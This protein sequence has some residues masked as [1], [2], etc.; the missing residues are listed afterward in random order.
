MGFN[1]LLR[2]T[3]LRR[4]LGKTKRRTN[5]PIAH[6]E[7]SPITTYTLR[8]SRWADFARGQRQN[9]QSQIRH[10]SRRFSETLPRRSPDLLVRGVL[11]TYLGFQPCPRC[12]P[13]TF[14]LSAQRIS[15]SEGCGHRYLTRYRKRMTE[16]K[17]VRPAAV[18]ACDFAPL[19]KPCQRPASCSAPVMIQLSFASPSSPSHSI[20]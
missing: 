10:R 16:K 14:T 5:N 4:W 20:H 8:E 7:S 13:G 6:R 18:V 11:P 19:P 3:R 12:L 9:S 17:K 2:V 1:Q 15:E